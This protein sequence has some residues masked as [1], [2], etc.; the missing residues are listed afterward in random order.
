V[1]ALERREAVFVLRMHA[2]ENRMRSDWIEAF[3]SALDEVEAS[4]GP[5]AL[6]TTGEDKFYSNGIDLGWLGGEG[7][8]HARA[9]LEALHRLFARVLAFPVPTVAAINGHAFAAGGMLAL[10]HDFRVMRSDRGYFCLPEVDLGLP[11][12]PGMLALIQ[13][14][15]PRATAHEAIVTGRR[16]AG[17]D[18]V[19][20]QIAEAAV[21]EDEV[22]PRALALAGELAGKHRATLSAL[23]RGLY[24][25]ALALLE[26]G[27]LA[28]A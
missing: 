20:R 6:V 19:A 11:L 15:L 18:A 27:G 8:P 4:Q 14:R 22:L 24:A 1:L 5:A 3:A 13:A 17:A 12:Q 23:K 25:D 21:R 26:R 28:D 16:Y 7:Q 2:G 10:A 9:F